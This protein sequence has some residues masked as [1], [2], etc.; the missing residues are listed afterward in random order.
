MACACELEKYLAALIDVLEGYATG[1]VGQDSKRRSAVGLAVWSRMFL[2]WLRTDRMTDQRREFV[3][4]GAP[5]P[6]VAGVGKIEVVPRREAGVVI[7][8]ENMAAACLEALTMSLA[9]VGMIG[10]TRTV[11]LVVAEKKDS[12]PTVAVRTD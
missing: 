9:L 2:M 6:V 7:G 10:V 3:D 8:G 5:A 4:G 11:A 12:R 1:T